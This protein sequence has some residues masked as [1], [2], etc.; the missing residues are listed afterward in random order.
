[1]TD[2][3]FRSPSFDAVGK[4]IPF[5]HAHAVGRNLFDGDAVLPVAVLHRS[6]VERNSAAMAEFCRREGVSL[7]PHG[8]TTMSPELFDLQLRDGAWAITAANVHQARVMRVH[9]VPRVLI[10][11][12][13][14]APA[15]IAWLADQVA[16]GFDVICYVDSVV[17]VSLLDEGIGSVPG[18]G[19]LSVLVELGVEGG[20]TGCRSVEDA[21]EVARAAADASSLRLIGASG[22]EGILVATADMTAEDRVDHFLGDLVLLAESIVREG[23]V[24][25]IDEFVLSAGG[26]V[27]FDRVVRALRSVQAAPSVRLVIRSGCYLS[28]DDGVIDELS[29]LGA[30]PRVAGGIF[31]AALTVWAPVLSRPEPGRLVL[32]AGKRDVSTDGLFPVAKA[33]VRRSTTAVLEFDGRP[34]AVKVDDQHAYIDVESTCPVGVG[35]HVGL[36]ISHPCTTFDKWRYLVVVD[37]S[38]GVVG[39]VTTCF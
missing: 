37:D 36:G 11:N 6:S 32:G 3:W 13:V 35:D 5:G 20:R 1:M 12:E 26:S 14:T 25:D 21:I 8:K 39:A 29:P 15:D 7:A 28:H 34:R 30:V 17:G 2:A 24:D 38:Y 33:W 23:L 4:G 9:G 10:A 27:Y 22:F 18:S 16:A 31:Q 19:R